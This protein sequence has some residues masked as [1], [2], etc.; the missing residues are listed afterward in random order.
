MC[1]HVKPD[2]ALL[3][4][5]RDKILKMADREAQKDNVEQ[6]GTSKIWV[7]PSCV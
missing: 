1:A 5:Y 7:F 2:N 4:R 3:H 6:R